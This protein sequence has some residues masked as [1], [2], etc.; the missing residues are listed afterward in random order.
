MKRKIVIIT[1]CLSLTMYFYGPA[2]GHTQELRPSD[3]KTVRYPANTTSGFIE[4][5]RQ[6]KNTESWPDYFCRVIWQLHKEERVHLS[7]LAIGNTKPLCRYITNT[8]FSVEDLGSVVV[9]YTEDIN[10]LMAQI[11]LTD[12]QTPAGH[13]VFELK[14]SRY[15]QSPLSPPDLYFIIFPPLPVKTHSADISFPLL[16]AA[17]GARVQTEEEFQEDTFVFMDITEIAEWILSKQKK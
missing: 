7:I 2:P 12:G 8:I 11:F 3:D 5:I 9:A 14:P 4:K 13:H 6:R 17:S 10:N 15:I 16:K 1:I